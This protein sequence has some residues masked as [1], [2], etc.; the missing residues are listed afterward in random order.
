MKNLTEQ[1][2]KWDIEDQTFIR[3]QFIP[4][5]PVEK[6]LEENEDEEE[7]EFEVIKVAGK[8]ESTSKVR[9]IDLNKIIDE[10]WQEELKRKNVKNELWEGAEG[11]LDGRG[12]LARLAREAL[13]KANDIDSSLQKRDQ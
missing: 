9:H 11:V 4:K 8:K 7:G 5:G 12:N 2:R 10:D 6:R 1:Q 13:E 3:K